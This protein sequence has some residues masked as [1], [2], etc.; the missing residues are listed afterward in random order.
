MKFQQ[1]K[2]QLIFEGSFA[3]AI[4]AVIGGGTYFISTMQ[5][6]YISRK[7]NME[8]QVS[9]VTNETNGL[10]EKYI[11]VQ[12]DIDLYEKVMRLNEEDMLSHTM[13][14][15]D[16][17]NREYEYTHNLVGGE[18]QLNIAEPTAHE[19]AKYKRKTSVLMTTD[20]TLR[21]QAANDEDV[22]RFMR[23]IQENYP[24]AVSFTGIQL[25]RVSGLTDEALRSIT[26][27][28][29]YNLV[30]S[31]INFKWYGINSLDPE[32]AKRQEQSRKRR[33]RRRRW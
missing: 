14:I 10:R 16:H 30:E 11:R 27:N 29:S 20:A 19:D 28:G 31:T 15:A 12:N 3:G 17:L 26:Q 9:A 21:F 23:D 33:G 5:D 24:G 1:L 22:Y 13:G 4:L 32:E 25:E 18:T 8:A 6:E 7:R 2:R